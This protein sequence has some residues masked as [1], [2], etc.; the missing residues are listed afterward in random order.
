MKGFLLFIF[1][2]KKK[3]EK[4]CR[5]IYK[6]VQKKQKKSKK[7]ENVDLKIERET[8]LYFHTYKCQEK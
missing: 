4:Y 6:F 3:K 8:L 1:W 7:L 5:H 2:R